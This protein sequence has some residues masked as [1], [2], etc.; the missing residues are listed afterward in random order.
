MQPLTL[1]ADVDLA[2]VAGADGA[3]PTATTSDPSFGRC[4]P[5]SSWKWLGD[6]YTPQCAAHDAAVRGELAQGTP[7]VLAHLKALP[8]LGPA[9]GSY[10]RA[11]FG[12]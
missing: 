1:L 7:R 4:G 5:G 8:L 2:R 10:V 12:R 3:P 9:V 11:R 6:V